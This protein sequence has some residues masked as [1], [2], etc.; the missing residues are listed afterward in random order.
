MCSSYTKSDKN[1]HTFLLLWECACLPSKKIT[2]TWHP[3]ADSSRT[4]RSVWLHFLTLFV[5]WRSSSNALRLAKG[6]DMYRVDATRKISAPKTRK[7]P[8]ASLLPIPFHMVI[9]LH[10]SDILQIFLSSH[11][12]W[13]ISFVLIDDV[14]WPA[15]FSVRRFLGSFHGGKPQFIS[16][17]N[18]FFWSGQFSQ[19]P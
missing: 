12:Y 3:T 4:I 10:V 8:L 9:D 13:S 1:H 11:F 5:F 16:I 2:L 15:A 7:F 19:D 6:T 14:C 18:P 17:C